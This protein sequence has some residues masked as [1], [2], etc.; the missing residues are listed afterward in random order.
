MEKSISTFQ[1]PFS[2]KR[3]T[4]HPPCST[5]PAGG[6]PPIW[7]PLYLHK[8][9]KGGREK[10]REGER[11]EGEGA[12]ETYLGPEQ[13]ISATVQTFLSQSPSK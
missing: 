1:H 11:R 5:D 3:N 12:R 7:T 9:V 8:V 4:S 6:A 13:Q 2:G 10:D